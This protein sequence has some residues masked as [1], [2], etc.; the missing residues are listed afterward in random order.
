M[1]TYSY[2]DVP[3]GLESYYREV[4]VVIPDGHKWTIYRCTQADCLNNEKFVAIRQYTNNILTADTLE[5]IISKVWDWE[6]F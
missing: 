2:L 6:Y 5:R 3:Y 4:Q 1:K